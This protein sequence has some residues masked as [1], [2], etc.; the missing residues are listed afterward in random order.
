MRNIGEGGLKGGIEPFLLLIGW[1]NN[2]LICV[3]M[4]DAVMCGVLCTLAMSLDE[5]FGIR[6]RK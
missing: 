3:C 6:D 1:S 5:Q 2:A 4:Y